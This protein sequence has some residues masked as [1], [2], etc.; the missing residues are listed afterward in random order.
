MINAVNIASIMPS[1]IEPSV[2]KIPATLKII[3]YREKPKIGVISGA[4]TM[5]PMIIEAL[6]SIRPME[7][8]A[9]A[10]A[11]S[12]KKSIVGLLYFSKCLK[13]LLRSLVAEE[14]KFN[15]VFLLFLLTKKRQTFLVCH[16]V[17][18]TI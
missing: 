4:T 15:I 14:K 8:M 13:V 3:K 2:L 18:N 10:T 9:E 5:P 11:V 1:K 7:M 17:A 6:S 12:K 16:S